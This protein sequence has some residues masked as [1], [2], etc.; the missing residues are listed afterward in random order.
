VSVFSD[1][2]RSRDMSGTAKALWSIFIIF[3]PYLGVFVYLIA[4]GG[5][6]TER[7]TRVVEQQEAEFRQY[8]QEAA[9]TGRTAAD[10][11]ATLAELHDR[12][13]ISDEEF[14]SLKAK[15]LA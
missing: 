4:R 9:G 2:I 12:G 13:K 10:Q 6:M 7:A 14:A 8:V 5:G 3:L 15:V 1:I 11:L